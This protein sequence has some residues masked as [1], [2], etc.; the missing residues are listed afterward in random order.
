[1][2]QLTK[3]TLSFDNGTTQDI[4]V[5]LQATTIDG[6]FGKIDLTGGA[7]KNPTGPEIGSNPGA[8][9]GTRLDPIAGW[10]PGVV[11]DDVDGTTYHM[12]QNNCGEWYKESPEQFKRYWKRTY[13]V[14]LDVSKCSPAQRALMGI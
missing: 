2:P 7:Q 11:F 5:G 14:D 8:Y 3:I 1:M 4:N 10:P 9:S 6:F 13:G 12:H